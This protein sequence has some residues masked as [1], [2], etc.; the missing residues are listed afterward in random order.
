MVRGFRIVAVLLAGLFLIGGG[1]VLEAA[2]LTYS[3]RPVSGIVWWRLLVILAIASTLFYFWWRARLGYWW[4]YSRLRLFSIVFPVVAVGT[5]LIP[6][7]YPRWMVVEQLLFS[8]LLIAVFALLS[9]PAF[10]A[11]YRRPGRSTPE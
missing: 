2:N 5:S 6:G 11:V 10:R 3:G 9:R 4:A 7:L 8:S 1:A